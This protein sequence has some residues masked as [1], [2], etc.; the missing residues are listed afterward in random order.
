MSTVSA[1][2]Y[3]VALRDELEAEG[4][5]AIEVFGRFYSPLPWPVIAAVL[6]TTEKRVRRAA[7]KGRRKMRIALREHKV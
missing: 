7:S 2:E 3:F 6:N 5:D 4:F 1:E